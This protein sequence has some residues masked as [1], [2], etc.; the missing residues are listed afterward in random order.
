MRRTP[1]ASIAIIL[2][3]IISIIAFIELRKGPCQPSDYIGTTC[4]LV[5]T[6]LYLWYGYNE[7]SHLWT[8]GLGTSHWNDTPSGLVKDRPSLGYYASLDNATLA[9]QFSEMKNAG[10]S[11]IVVSWWGTGNATQSVGGAPTLD[12]AINNATLN[13]FRYLE[14]T[15]NQ[16]QFKVAIMVEPFHPN[17]TMT[18]HDYAKLYTFLYAH[19]YHPYDDLIL[20][21]QGKPL[22]LSF[23]YKGPGFGRLPA[24]ST[25]TYRLVGGVPNTVDWNFWAGMNFLDA[26]GGTAEPQN[27]GRDPVVSPDGEVGIAPRYDDYYLWL[28]NQRQGYMRFDYQMNEGMYGSEWD[29]V[30]GQKFV[31][32]VLIYSWNEYHERTSIEPHWDYSAQVSSDYLANL[33]ASYIAKLG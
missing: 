13:L 33:T 5:G 18:S 19:Y 22:L 3:I 32:L 10:I 30:L 11:V 21:W 14:A 23:N 25:F 9:T 20:S 7:T 31:G 8:G 6:F 16:W 15:K 4:P 2:V 1:W 24:N 27:Y 29:Y 17:Y 12:A 26:S 28:A